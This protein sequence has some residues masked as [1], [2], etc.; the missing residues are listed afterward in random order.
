MVNALLHGVR[1]ILLHYNLAPQVA[2]ALICPLE[3]FTRE[4]VTDAVIELVEKAEEER[5]KVSKSSSGKK[6]PNKSSSDYLTRTIK[7]GQSQ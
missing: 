4:S 3:V 1:R 5:K 7:I 6:T 2:S